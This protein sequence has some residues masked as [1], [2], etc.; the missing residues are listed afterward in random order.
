MKF[1]SVVL[2][3]ALTSALPTAVA[4]KEPATTRKTAGEAPS[5][6]PGVVDGKA[7]HAL[8]AGGIKVV[9]VRTPGEFAAG[10]VP[11]AVN[12]PFDEMPRRFSEVGPPAAPVLVYCKSGRRSAIAIGTLREKGFTKIYDLQAYDRWVAAEPASPAR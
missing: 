5:V 12:I 3:L 10:H 11:G 7:A 8:V 1:F 6:P 2:A 4:E 9:D